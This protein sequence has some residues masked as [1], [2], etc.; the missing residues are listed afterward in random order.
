MNCPETVIIRGD[1]RIS[2]GGGGGERQMGLEGYH[3]SSV[4][5]LQEGKK[6]EKG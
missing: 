2:W 5:W 3:A 4:A 1:E 6:D